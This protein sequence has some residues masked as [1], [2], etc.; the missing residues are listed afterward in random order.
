MLLDFQMS[1]T[2]VTNYPGFAHLSC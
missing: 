1:V 2:F